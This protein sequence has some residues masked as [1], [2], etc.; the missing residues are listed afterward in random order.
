[1]TIINALTQ[2]SRLSFAI[3]LVSV[4]ALVLLLITHETAHGNVPNPSGHAAEVD[5]RNNIVRGIR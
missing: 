1:M 2:P 5:S 4:V 3:S